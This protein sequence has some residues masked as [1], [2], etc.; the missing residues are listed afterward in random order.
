MHGRQN[1]KDCQKL[2]IYF[3]H[4]TFGF[5]KTHNDVRLKSQARVI[6]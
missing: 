3:Y 4:F 5:Y 2:N 1:V 6:V